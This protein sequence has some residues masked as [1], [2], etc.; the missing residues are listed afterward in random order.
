MKFRV[1]TN[2]AEVLKKYGFKLPEE[3]LKSGLLEGT[4]VSKYCMMDG[5]FYI[6][7]MDEED[8][9]KIAVE[10]EFKNPLLTGWI[11]TRNDRNTLW[12]DV[13]PWGTYHS[14][15]D[16][17]ILMMDVIYELTLDGLLERIEDK[18]ESIKK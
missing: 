13:I 5:C 15:M 8:S 16:D 9:S 2:D 3:W 17:L 1:K 14:G 11:D 7:Q 12:F 18:K 4:N 6:Y 10:D